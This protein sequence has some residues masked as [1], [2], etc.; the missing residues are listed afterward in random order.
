[1][2]PW[3]YALPVNRKIPVDVDALEIVNAFPDAVPPHRG[4]IPVAMERNGCAGC[5]ANGVALISH[6]KLASIDT[7]VRTH[8]SIWTGTSCTGHCDLRNVVRM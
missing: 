2:S 8:R 5:V 6:N 3:R 4:E 1:M 7:A